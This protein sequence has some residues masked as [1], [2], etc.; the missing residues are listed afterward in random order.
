MPS[1]DFTKQP[2]EEEDEVSELGKKLKSVEMPPR[3]RKVITREFKRLKKLN[4][5]QAEYN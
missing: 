3:A 1:G 2:E 4:Q 5:G